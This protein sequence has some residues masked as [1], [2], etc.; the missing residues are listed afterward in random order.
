LIVVDASVIVTALADDGED[1]DHTRERL[2]A[3]RLVAPHLI[4]LEVVSAW[5]RL[6]A[7][8]GL[9]ERR[10]QLAL[11]DLRVLRLERVPHGPLLSRCWEL[12]DNLTVYDAAYVA[13][14]E[15]LDATLLTADARLARESAA[16]CEIEL[17]RP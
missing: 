8:A 4:D 14:A 15:A 7:A 6:A 9:D 11:E 1:G 2:R 12:R 13:L 3:E 10:A 5:R 17:I 16:H